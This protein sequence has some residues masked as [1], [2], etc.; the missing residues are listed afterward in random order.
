ML[1][2]DRP[3]D[4][5]IRDQDH[6]IEAREALMQGLHPMAIP[7]ADPVDR[8]PEVALE[9]LLQSQSQKR[10]YDLQPRTEPGEDKETVLT[11]LSYVQEHE[12][13]LEIPSS[14]LSHVSEPDPML[15]FPAMV[16]FLKYFESF[17]PQ[18]TEEQR[19][20]F[21]K[22]KTELEEAY[23]QREQ[24]QAVSAQGM[25]EEQRPAAQQ[26]LQEE[27]AE[28]RDQLLALDENDHKILFTGCSVNLD[29]VLSYVKPYLPEA[30]RECLDGDSMDETVNR[31][32]T[33]IIASC[34]MSSEN[35]DMMASVQESVRSSFKWLFQRVWEKKDVEELEENLQE[36][37]LQKLLKNLRGILSDQQIMEIYNAYHRDES[38]FN[39]RN[40]VNTAVQKSFGIFQKT[41]ERI[42]EATVQMIP[43]SFSYILTHFLHVGIKNE[44]VCIEFTKQEDGRY[45]L[46]I[47]GG[48]SSHEHHLDVNEKLRMPLVF[49]NIE[50]GMITAQ[51]IQTLLAFN[52][53]SKWAGVSY[54]LADIYN[55][56]HDYLDIEPQPLETETSTQAAKGSDLN[57]IM[58]LL[59]RD[60]LS[61]QCL[62]Q[63]PEEAQIDERQR[64]SLSDLVYFHLHRQALLD[65][66]HQLNSNAQDFVRGASTLRLAC[67]RV[68]NE[69]QRLFDRQIIT[70]DEKARSIATTWHILRLVSS[71]E[72]TMAPPQA[73]HPPVIIPDNIRMMIRGILVTFGMD[74]RRIDVVKKALAN[75][76][77]DN[78]RGSINHIVDEIIG[79]MEQE[80][81]EATWSEPT[82]VRSEQP[83]R[84]PLDMPALKKSKIETQISFISNLIS[85]VFSH[86]STYIFTYNSLAFL[87]NNLPASVINIFPPSLNPQTLIGTISLF[88][89]FSLEQLP[90]KQKNKVI[91]SV[92]TFACLTVNT[93]MARVCFVV[94]EKALCM[95]FPAAT[96]VSLLANPFITKAIYIGGGY[97][98][99]K[100]L[101]QSVIDWYHETIRQVQEYILFHVLTFAGNYFVTNETKEDLTTYFAKA[102]SVI[103]RSGHL[104]LDVPEEA[105][106]MGHAL[107]KRPQIAALGAPEELEPPLGLEIEEIVSVVESPTQKRLK[108]SAENQTMYLQYERL[109]ENP[110]AA[111]IEERLDVI[112]E[113]AERRIKQI[114]ERRKVES[115]VRVIL[116]DI[117]QAIVDLSIQLPFLDT[118]N[119]N[120]ETNIWNR[121]EDKEKMLQRLMKVSMLLY[122]SALSN[123]AH[124]I[125]YPFH[126][127]NQIKIAQ[128]TFFAISNH[129]ARQCPASQL[130]DQEV[131]LLPLA[132]FVHQIY[133]SISNPEFS[134]RLEN[135]C[136]YFHIDPYERIPEK[137]LVE[138][139]ALG[140]LFFFEEMNRPETYSHSYT[141]LSVN[142]WDQTDE[143][144]FNSQKGFYRN[145][146]RHYL[147][148]LLDDPNT[149]ARMQLHGIEPT[150]AL[151]TRM[152]F[153]MSN[154]PAFKVLEEVAPE[155]YEETERVF[156]AGKHQEDEY[157]GLLPQPF[158]HLW[159][160]SMLCETDPKSSSGGGR[161]VT[162]ISGLQSLEKEG[163]FKFSMAGIGQVEL[164]DPRE[165]SWI[166]P[167]I[168]PMIRAGNATNRGLHNLTRRTL[169][170]K[171][172]TFPSLPHCSGLEPPSYPITKEFGLAFTDYPFR[173]QH[174]SQWI[175]S[176]NLALNPSWN[177][178]ARSAEEDRQNG[179]L[180]ASPSEFEFYSQVRTLEQGSGSFFSERELQELAMIPLVDADQI[181]RTLSH[182]KQHPEKFKLEAFQHLFAMICLRLSSLTRQVE[183]SEDTIRAFGVFFEEMLQIYM[184]DKD[185][186]TTLF[187]AEM[188][189]IFHQ[190]IAFIDPA[191]TQ[192]FLDIKKILLGDLMRLAQDLKEDPMTIKLLY[193]M[194]MVTY[195][196]I[197][198]LSLSD[199]ERKVICH[200][201][202]LLQHIPDNLPSSSRGS[203]KYE[204]VAT[205]AVH[206]FRKWT[207]F[208]HRHANELAFR[209]RLIMSLL[210]AYQINIPEAD[211]TIEWNSNAG[212]IKAFDTQRKVIIFE[213]N[214]FNFEAYKISTQR[215]LGPEEREQERPC[216]EED[217][218]RFYPVVLQQQ[219]RAIEPEDTVVTLPDEILDVLPVEATHFWLEHTESHNQLLLVRNENQTLMTLQ[220][221][222][223]QDAVDQYDEV[224]DQ[225]DVRILQRFKDEPEQTYCQV[226]FDQSFM[227]GLAPLRWFC[228]FEEM[229]TYAPLQRQNKIA[230]VEL[231][232]Y[233]LSLRV[234]TDEEEVERTYLHGRAGNYY[235][236]EHQKD[237]TLTPFSQYLVFENEENQ[238][239]AFV[240]VN[241]FYTA[242]ADPLCSR[243]YSVMSSDLVR[244]LANS[245][246]ETL[247][248]SHLPT[249]Q[250]VFEYDITDSGLTS[251]DPSA[252]IYLFIYNLINNNQSEIQRIFKELEVVA[253]REALPREVLKL[254]PLLTLIASVNSSN[255]NMRI[256][257]LKLHALFE[258]NE[259]LQKENAE[260]APE[261]EENVAITVIQNDLL[262]FGSLQLLYKKYLDGVAFGQPPQLNEFEELFILRKIRKIS[263]NMT[264]SVVNQM[265]TEEIQYILNQLG[266]KFFADNFVLFS[267]I[268]LRWRH[269]SQLHAID[270]VEENDNLVNSFLL[271]WMH[272][273]R[274]QQQPLLT[275]ALRFTRILPQE[276]SS[277]SLYRNVTKLLEVYASHPLFRFSK[278]NL[279]KDLQLADCVRRVKTNVEDLTEVPLQVEELT[280]AN[281]EQYFIAYYCLCRKTPLP[282]WVDTVEKRELFEK[283]SQL[284]QKSIALKKGRYPIRHQ[285]FLEYLKAAS[286]HGN[287]YNLPKGIILRNMFALSAQELELR[288]SL[289]PEQELMNFQYKRLA[290]F[291]AG[292]H[293]NF[294]T[295]SILKFFKERT[296]SYVK[297]KNG[298]LSD[299][300]TWAVGFAASS[301][302]GLPGIT[303]VF[304]GVRRFS[305]MIEQLSIAP[306]IYS[307]MK[308]AKAKI[309]RQRQELLAAAVEQDSGDLS[310]TITARPTRPAP[311]RA[312]EA[313]VEMQPA[314]VA[315]LLQDA[316]TE[317][318]TL[319]QSTFRTHL[320]EEEIVPPVIINSTTG[321]PD[322]FLF[323]SCFPSFAF[324]KTLMPL[325][326]LFLI[327]ILY[328]ESNF[329]NKIPFSWLSNK[330]PS[331]SFLFFSFTIISSPIFA[332][333]I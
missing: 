276:S 302:L 23:H 50:Q 63:I 249:K 82:E 123:E 57:S 185:I 292:I 85:K 92:A 319:L 305:P 231:P 237:P 21:L 9:E 35:A 198:P 233:D 27:S 29:H 173:Y 78:V 25:M 160:Q 167:V 100:L 246:L 222:A 189:V 86:I 121:V 153:L 11:G 263:H 75:I 306:T 151:T 225:H 215:A 127:Q 33:S 230:R 120:I 190:H 93:L 14:V 8:P 89:T 269:L 243:L 6:L 312:Q 270:D 273:P 141:S 232:R 114:Q 317:V 126:V 258:E 187:L 45:R 280:E 322:I 131:N 229:T 259:R 87:H 60:R 48:L 142:Y 255:E 331:S 227:G 13:P 15:S 137:S 105:A 155:K 138:K 47:Y 67:F 323:S 1:L 281:L 178:L 330:M 159:I 36:A 2:V 122:Q 182:L 174:N 71:K 217:G 298:L 223:H 307:E 24:M 181:I 294:T 244:T 272:A 264:E 186:K 248:E 164:L 17:S 211:L 136:E 51:F 133:S 119:P 166:A 88:A 52:V 161:Q 265:N 208:M 267:T 206:T 242:I 62:E 132:L 116:E 184:K 66:W 110:S 282:E 74:K 129:L 20:G 196:Y 333:F 324:S 268:S 54:T 143:S 291:F 202:F 22:L 310:R 117:T 283:R 235:L 318:E 309:A 245:V 5:L 239:K 73:E 10:T 64:S 104:H 288:P 210:E 97:V 195:E 228:P 157:L 139:Y 65:G 72:Q 40:I 43:S 113:K 41:I 279:G 96:V 266:I 201:L 165:H 304:A 42:M 252:L 219:R 124:R 218:K 234:R 220:L 226:H 299:V 83:V 99:G 125:G 30:L 49:T 170:E 328:P 325:A 221:S 247:S 90:E 204:Y 128:F 84:P 308:K 31:I 320:E 98:I 271:H 39:I 183:E 16:D 149:V 179:I 236:C 106:L 144:H 103:T 107:I 18:L 148:K 261:R 207:P 168:N 162:S 194:A 44:T 59:L 300:S 169:L 37:L 101:P 285:L 284:L 108:R 112:I 262:L 176:A 290:Q 163:F 26:K 150:E 296:F 70:E 68:A 81:R 154:P 287:P 53:D 240:S 205:R 28:I 77:G 7:E 289:N 257:I 19:A 197:D 94:L 303:S 209:K 34:Q 188:A 293:S 241:N 329:N 313:P 111:V 191:K 315:E 156:K 58:H 38:V 91:N 56:I 199:E 253:R 140:R 135:I 192:L 295:T 152:A 118:E 224:V 147:L 203:S 46:A 277:F 102:E 115:S 130:E 55:A 145:P 212:T 61:L 69:A 238:R 326:S 200:E 109:P 80:Q 216:L 146:H 4:P 327:P 213:I 275:R 95:A 32:S 301:A 332:F 76:I 314:T 316:D 311:E 274:G 12:H 134:R 180:N 79:E 256:I 297:S 260:T 193:N 177:P 172:I 286:M 251:S 3:V 321:F 250:R 158:Y 171:T 278:R 254:L 214:V 175:Q